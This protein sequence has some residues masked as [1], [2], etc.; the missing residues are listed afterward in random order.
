M[1][2]RSYPVEEKL[3]ILR[4]CEEDNYSIYKIASIYKVNK[5]TIMEWKHKFDK[6][7]ID[8]LKEST[9]KKMYSK[10]LKLSAIRDYQSGEYSLREISRKYGL[11]D[12]STL[13]NWI[14]KYNSH[15]EIKETSKE[16]TSSMTKGRKTTWDERIQIVI[17]CLGNGKDYQKTAELHNVSYQQVYQWVKKYE[18]GGDEA[19]KDNRGRT[20]EEAELTP[21][22][23]IKIQFKK[24]ERENERLRAENMFFKKVRGDRK[25]AKVSQIRFEDKYIAIQELHEKENLS[26]SLL[27]EIAGIARSAYYK[28]LNRTPSS[29]EILNKEI[30]KEMKILHEKV[31]S[32]FGYRQMTLHMNRKFEEKLN[33]KRIYR[34]M[35]VAGLRSV[36]RIKKKQ[37]KSTTPQQVAEN[38][39]NREFTAEKPNEKWV[40]DVTEFK[41][42]QS[43]KAYLSAIRDLYDGSIVSYVLGH[44]NNN[45]LV[46]KTLD[47]ATVLLDGEHPLIH[48]DRGFQYTSK[49]FKRKIDAV[50]M[51]QSMSR[52]GR[53]IDNGPMESFWGTLKCEKYYLHQYQT[54]EEL[55][56][57]IDEYIHFYNY[58]RYQKRLNGLSPMEYRAKAA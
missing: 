17:N 4:A 9:S 57:A 30:I 13:S 41:Y 49:G 35:K 33:H 46:F 42:G 43:K 1:S 38:I 6:D 29:R 8:G 56:L 44:S 10:E 16:R 20:K 23:K 19:L 34:L 28:W 48:S 22:E 36:I 58:D 21:E 52:V 26:I 2:K 37:Y 3:K 39:L 15:R 24:L 53:C 50:K 5:S 40:T 32:T 7:G 11:T 55:S 18:N 54:F 47:Q 27:C 14:K 12:K 45:Q 31:D 51:T 25:E